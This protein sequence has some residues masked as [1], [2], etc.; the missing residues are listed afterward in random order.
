MRLGLFLASRTR[1]SFLCFT[2]FFPQQKTFFFV[3]ISFAPNVCAG[4]YLLYNSIRS[5]FVGVSL[6]CLRKAIATHI[7]YSYSREKPDQHYAFHFFFIIAST[8]ISSSVALPGSL[9]AWLVE[10][11]FACSSYCLDSV[12]YFSYTLFFVS[13]LLCLSFFLVGLDRPAFSC[14]LC[15]FL[16]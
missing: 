15:R 1:F 16:F 5:I 4:R 13:V 12:Q 6:Q 14:L 11:S 9:A 10:C 2:P 3:K 7:L 8:L